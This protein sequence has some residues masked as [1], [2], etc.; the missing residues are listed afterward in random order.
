[1]PE[2][3]KFHFTPAD[4]AR[5]NEDNVHVKASTDVSD[6]VEI[7]KNEFPDGVTD[8]AVYAGEYTVFVKR[9]SLLQVCTALKHTLGFSYLVDLAGVDCFSG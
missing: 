9:D 5:A 1:M 8:V 3:L 7:L 4:D 2:S 6:T